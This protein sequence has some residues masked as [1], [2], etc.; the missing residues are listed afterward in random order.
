MFSRITAFLQSG[1]LFMMRLCIIYLLM[2]LVGLTQIL[3]PPLPNNLSRKASPY[4]LSS[5]GERADR[6]E[7]KIPD[8]FKIKCSLK[9]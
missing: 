7:I 1:A 5:W 8:Q 3:P 9:I 4:Y 6:S 2:G